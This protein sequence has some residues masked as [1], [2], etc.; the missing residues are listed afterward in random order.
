ML[1]TLMTALFFVV[2]AVR[3]VSVG[4][5]GS[6]EHLLLQCHSLLPGAALSWGR[7]RKGQQFLLALLGM[8]SV[9][10]KPPWAGGLGA[11]WGQCEWQE[12]VVILVMIVA[13]QLFLFLF[14]C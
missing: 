7:E 9:P 3:Q 13:E 5:V 1:G 12:G 8:A 4:S 11:L 2:R 14:P 10:P 6:R